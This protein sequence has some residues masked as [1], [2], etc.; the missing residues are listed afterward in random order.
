MTNLTTNSVFDV[1]MFIYRHLE[2]KKKLKDK[3]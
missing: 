2:L 1:R 3:K